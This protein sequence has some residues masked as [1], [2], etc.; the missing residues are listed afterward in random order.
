MRNVEN[1][2]CVSM[3][4]CCC[5]AFLKQS[6]LYL[7]QA[8]F[9]SYNSVWGGGIKAMGYTNGGG[10]QVAWK[11]TLPHGILH[12]HKFMYKKG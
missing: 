4:L 6:T 8:K 12:A 10:G 5:N 3:R 1:L 7:N 2:G 11:A 9:L